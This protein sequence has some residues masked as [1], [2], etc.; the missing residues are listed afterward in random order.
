MTDLTKNSKQ[1]LVSCIIIFLN[2]EESFFVEAIESVFAQTYDNWELLLVDDGS[3]N[4]STA[5]ALSYAQKYPDHVRYLEH[6]GHRNLGMSAARNLGIK[7]SK[8]EFVAL[9]DAD[10]I[11]LPEK[12]TKQVAILQAH[13]KAAMVYGSTMRWFS[14]TGNPEDALRDSGRPLG[15]KTDTMVYPPALLKVFLSST[16]NTP[17]T[18]GT[19]LRR[20]FIN[21]VGGFEET[22][23]GL[24]ED[25][26][27]F[28]KLCLKAPVFVESGCWDKYRQHSDSTCHIHN[29]EQ[30]KAA[31]ILFLNWLEAYLVQQ[32][33]RDSEVWQAFNRTI[34]PYRHQRLHEL[35]QLYNQVIR[36][37]RLRISILTKSMIQVY[38]S[39]RI[40]HAKE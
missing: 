28:Y 33:I 6:D 13:P 19:L 12:L 37:I 39:A 27:F 25:Q 36:A 2:A 30:F 9:L 14:W 38:C 10:D 1:H 16:D 24:F 40:S 17:A 15:V 11:W 23:R 8:G 35:Q 5:I 18:C 3:I 32:L 22:F 20:E 4:Q 31:H 7:H 29:P 34:W 21:S 26:A